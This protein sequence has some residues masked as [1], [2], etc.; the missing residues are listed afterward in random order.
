MSDP[1]YPALCQ[2]NTRVWLT[3]LSLYLDE[4]PWQAHAF[5]LTKNANWMP[6]R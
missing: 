4:R 1:R 3:E 5:P 2:I 6:V